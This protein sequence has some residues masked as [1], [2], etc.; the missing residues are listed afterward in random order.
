MVRKKNISEINLIYYSMGHQMWQV[1]DQ[2]NAGFGICRISDHATILSKINLRKAYFH[3]FPS[4]GMEINTSF[5][6]CRSK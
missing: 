4:P 3:P 6:I 5:V 1:Q 2:H